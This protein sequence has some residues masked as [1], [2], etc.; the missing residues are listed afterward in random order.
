MDLIHFSQCHSG[1]R[2][3]DLY[4]EISSYWIHKPHRVPDNLVRRDDEVAN[5]RSAV[6]LSFVS[7]A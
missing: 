1:F 2:F 5:V 7:E 6:T 4:H 3:N